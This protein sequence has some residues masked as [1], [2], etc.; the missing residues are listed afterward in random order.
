M[1]DLC[2][3][4][5]VQSSTEDAVETKYIQTSAVPVLSLDLACLIRSLNLR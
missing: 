3:F 1:Y 5:E 2:T 4:W